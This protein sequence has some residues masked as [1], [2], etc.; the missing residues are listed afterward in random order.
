[1]KFFHV[2]NDWHIKGLEKNNFINEDSG[3]KIQ[4]KF[5]IPEQLKFNK[6]A[7]KGVTVAQLYQ[8][9]SSQIKTEATSAD[10]TVDNTSVTVTIVDE[11]DPVKSRWA[12]RR[13]SCPTLPR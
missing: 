10:I 5:A 9:L 4:H 12:I 13:S 3:F 8:A 7:A 11:T 1:M 2:Y 6:L